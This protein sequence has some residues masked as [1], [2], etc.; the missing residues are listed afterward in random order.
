M[1]K[2]TSKSANA[3]DAAAKSEN[4][5][6]AETLSP[7]EHALEDLVAVEFDRDVPDAGMAFNNLMRHQD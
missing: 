6:L 5:G 3:N 2:D 7:E 1:A 4:K